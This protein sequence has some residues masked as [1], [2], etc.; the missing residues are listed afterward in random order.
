M[1]ALAPPPNTAGV[2][3]P[4]V[5]AN[6]ASSIDITLAKEYVDRLSSNKRETIDFLGAC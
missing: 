1:A 4:P 2:P 3:L 6:P 5:P